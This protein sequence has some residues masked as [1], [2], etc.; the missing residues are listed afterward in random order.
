[1]GEDLNVESAWSCA[2]GSCRGEGVTIAVVDDGLEIAHGDLSANVSTTL[3]HRVYSTTAAPSDGDPTPS[4][5][6]HYHGTGVGGIIAA[7]DDN[8]IGGR[9]VAPRA[10]LVG[11]GFLQAVNSSNEVDAMTYQAESI[12]ISNNSWGPPDGTGQ[13][14]DSSSLWRD[15]IN[16]GLTNGR[17]G[18]GTIY[19]W[20]AG[21]GHLDGDSSNYDGY[22]NYGGVIAV[23]AVNAQGVRS[24]YSEMGANLWISGTG[25][26]SCRTLGITS[27]DRSGTSGANTGSSSNDIADADHTA[28]MN[29]TSSATP[30]VA[31]VVALMLQA[32]PALTWRDVRMILAVTA[33]QNDAANVLWTANTAGHKFNY[34]Y[35]FGVADANAAV[36]T[37]R[38]WTNLSLLIEHQNATQTVNAAIPDNDGT[39][40]RHS[41]TVSS[42]GISK[43]EW[44]DITFSASDHTYSGDLKVTL[45]APSGTQSVLSVPHSCSG[46]CTPHSSWRFGSARHLNEPADG[47]W[48][49]V[50]QDLAAEDIGTFESWQL[51]IYGH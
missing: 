18:L 3:K 19:L 29:G 48:Q 42:S 33:R 2:D 50:V 21:N 6:E 32:N 31:G 10:S 9:G 36:T 11:Y 8:G 26:E 4:A 46:T 25:G 17:G 41:L 35:G 5:A 20:A 22:A 38:N 34:N 1:M 45:I 37:A 49:L 14:A 24:S 47:T 27:T 15:A 12:A 43:I 16:H 28:C 51:S 13:L 44:V 40:V 39:D 23:A 30:S 7:R